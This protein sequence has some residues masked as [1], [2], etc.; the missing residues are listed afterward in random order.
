[1]GFG[2]R[3]HWLHIGDDHVEICDEYIMMYRYQCQEPT[4][5]ASFPA[6][7]S[8]PPPHRPFSMNCSNTKLFPPF[9][10]PWRFSWHKYCSN[11][12]KLYSVFCEQKPR[13]C[14]MN[15]LKQVHVPSWKTCLAGLQLILPYS[16]GRGIH[17]PCQKVST[18][19][20]CK[21]QVFQLI[22][23]VWYTTERI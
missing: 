3:K 13:H 2:V 15:I 8:P 20:A 5:S 22:V 10:G 6:F 23:P 14:I 11:T 12:I 1:M 19:S 9:I 18:N 17:K 16:Y 7:D 21:R 4:K